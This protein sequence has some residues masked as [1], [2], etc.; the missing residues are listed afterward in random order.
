MREQVDAK[1]CVPGAKQFTELK[2]QGKAW[3]RTASA[4]N[5]KVNLFS[6]LGQSFQ[7]DAEIAQQLGG[8]KLW[9]S[10]RVQESLK[11]AQSLCAQA[12]PDGSLKRSFDKL[13][14]EVQADSPIR[15]QLK[16]LN[17]EERQIV[18]GRQILA[19]MESVRLTKTL[20]NKMERGTARERLRDKRRNI[21]LSYPMSQELTP[22]TVQDHLQDQP[23]FTK[24]SQ[25]VIS[26]EEE[27][28]VDFVLGLTEDEKSAAQALSKLK[29][30]RDLNWSTLIAQK[31]IAKEPLP[32]K[33]VKVMQE[34]WE[35]T[36]ATKVE[37][38]GKM[39]DATTC[40][41]YDMSHQ[42]T[43]ELLNS[44]PAHEQQNLLGDMCHCNLSHGTEWLPRGT[45]WVLGGAV[46]GGVVSCLATNVACPAL[47]TI[48]VASATITA[49]DS[50]VNLSDSLRIGRSLQLVRPLR[51]LD[52]TGLEKERLQKV[53]GRAALKG[54]GEAAMASTVVGA[55]FRHAF[56]PIQ[57][58]KDVIRSNLVREQSLAWRK[59]L[60]DKYPQ[61]KDLPK[62]EL[63]RISKEVTEKG[64]GFVAEVLKTK[65]ISVKSYLN[66]DGETILKYTQA[67]DFDSMGGRIVE[68]VLAVDAKTGAIDANF[69]GGQR[70]VQAIFES[71]EDDLVLIFKDLNHLGATNYFHHGQAAGDLY[72]QAFGAAV[73]QNLRPGDLMLKTGGDELVS[74]VPLKD[75]AIAQNPEK[76]QDA[77]NGLLQRMVDAV[78][79]S[80]EAAAVFKTQAKVLVDELKAVDKALSAQDL[81]KQLAAKLTPEQMQLASSN[82]PQFRAEFL[83]AQKEMI[84]KHVAY[85]P[86]I[87]IGATVVKPGG[88]YEEAKLLA[89]TQAKMVKV[90]Y[91]AQMGASSEE[92]SKYRVPVK[93]VE[94]TGLR[95]VQDIKPR[96]LNPAILDPGKAA[97]E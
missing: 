57:G 52:M 74:V 39:C 66:Q 91:K 33:L 64:E 82:F 11:K 49:A 53:S 9:Q 79:N 69:P 92:L 97:K 70:L 62:A 71:A 84:K 59:E 54:L 47:A 80:K 60:L 24:T 46:L 18:M 37:A 95:R 48:G 26:R 17:E 94:D 77:V 73:R 86:S 56:S 5:I 3:V 28:L 27:H 19:R 88:S 7:F 85:R 32:Q 38:L 30:R 81:P 96:P 90:D 21:Q 50:V 67:A 34:D 16:K 1:V 51:G 43:L 87:S 2:L 75:P 41:A 35:E 6:K 63:E 42:I 83:T 93:P 23:N 40:E 58:T 61:Y 15:A 22:W 31:I 12:A 25:L 76:V 72:L 44:T 10:K 4:R 13:I 36:Y 89:E 65:E 45:N 78:H 68:R 20:N 29:D 8:V 14:G 55:N